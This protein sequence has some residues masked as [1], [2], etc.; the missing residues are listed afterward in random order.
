MRAVG[1][2]ALWTV[3][4]GG[5]LRNRVCEKRC[6]KKNWLA[7]VWTRK[8]THECGR[9]SVLFSLSLSPRVPNFYRTVPHPMACSH[10]LGVEVCCEIR[11]ETCAFSKSG[12]SFKALLHTATGVVHIGV[13][14]IPTSAC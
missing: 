1:G 8:G 3:P 6:G 4:V 5:S 12:L 7:S 13:G 2:Q 14:I 9:R 11:H 10:M